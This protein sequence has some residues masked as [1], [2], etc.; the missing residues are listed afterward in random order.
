MTYEQRRSSIHYNDIY[1]TKTRFTL[2]CASRNQLSTIY[3]RSDTELHAG[4]NLVSAARNFIEPRPRPATS[5][6]PDSIPALK[7]LAKCITPQKF[8]RCIRNIQIVVNK[9]LKFGSFRISL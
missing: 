6:D 9:E 8:Y 5:K 1:A 7:F 4:R 3:Q 2:C